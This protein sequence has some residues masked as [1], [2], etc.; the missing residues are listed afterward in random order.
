MKLLVLTSEAISAEQLRDALPAGVDPEQAEV[1]LV[2]PA[3]QES[4][5]RFW[6]SDADDAI[7]RADHVRRESLERLGSDDIAASGD[8]GE[9]DPIDAIEDALET[10]DADRIVIFTHPEG[11]QRYR[12]DVDIDEVTERFGRPVDHAQV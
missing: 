11:G 9:A 8:T 2:A 4:A 6:V 7:T 3:L 12:E 5:L 10:F 1:M